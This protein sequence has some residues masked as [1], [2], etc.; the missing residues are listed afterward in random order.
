MI[1]LDASLAV[2]LLL[3]T[4][5]AIPLTDDLLAPQEDL[6]APHL[7]EVE[8]TQTLR[9]LCS[10]AELTDRRA[11]EAMTDLADLP[12]VRHSHELLLR[13]AWELRLNL[14]IYDGIYVALAELLEVPLWTLDRRIAGAPGVRAEVRVIV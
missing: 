7:I 14:T 8:V 2:E 11:E 6:H 5:R 4:P 9:R 3:Q 10:R 13:R 1:V 12:L